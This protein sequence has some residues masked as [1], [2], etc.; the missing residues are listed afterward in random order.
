[1]AGNIFAQ[2]KV[3][4]EVIKKEEKKP[5]AEMNPSFNV[6]KIMDENPKKADSDEVKFSADSMESDNN[7][8]LITAIGNVD[9]EY[10]NMFLKADKVVYDQ[11]EDRVTATGNVK[12][13]QENGNVVYAD[14]VTAS[15]KMSKAFMEKIKVEMIDGT[16]IM[17]DS[18]RKRANNDKVIEKAMYTP[19]DFCEKTAP[20]W[21]INARKVKHDAASQDVNYNDAVLKVKNVPVIYTPYLSHPDPEVKRRSG[22]LAPT[23]GKN[24][25]LGATLQT[26][27]FFDIDEHQ[28]FTFTPIFT[29]DKEVVLMGKYNKYFYSGEMNVEGSYLHDK[30]DDHKEHRGNIFASG[31]YE[32]NNYWVADADLKYVSDNLYLKEL[33]LPQKDDAW[34]VSNVRMQMFDNRDYASIEAYYYDLVSYNLRSKRGRRYYQQSDNKPFVLP[35]MM[36]ENISDSNSVGAYFKNTFDFASVY[37][38]DDNNGQRMSMINSWILPYTSRFGEKYRFVASLKSDVYYINS[39]RNSYNKDYTGVA[40][41]VFPQVGVEWKYPFIRTGE[42]SS[43]IIEPVT[44]AVVAP[45]GGN[46]EH[47]IP[48]EDSQDVDLDD[49]NILNLDRF[50]GY[51]RNDTGSRISYGFNWSSYGERFGRTTAFIAQSYRFNRSESFARQMGEEGSFSDYVGRIYASPSKYFNLDYRFRADKDKLKIKYSELGAGI[52]SD[53]FKVYVSYIYIN[54]KLYNSENLRE[55]HELY[56]SI[57]SA[58]TKDWSIAL[59][60]RQDLTKD[61]GNL[62]HGGSLIYE[63]ECLKFMTNVSKYNSNNPNLDDGYSFGFTF[64]LKTLGGFGA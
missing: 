59:Y 53:I 26:P 35:L 2:E 9:I 17:A 50:S 19:C 11:N 45:N 62:E 8:G 18:F 5:F 15:D 13:T 23:I 4:G 34:L 21:Q 40:T 44:L 51:D 63:D 61:G 54:S 3:A 24:S 16:T 47:K 28:D 32:I 29:T 20:L 1:M 27:Y 38:E 36:Y 48:N 33:S 64:Y 58:L 39:Y 41:R 56:T 55:R 22:F 49:S 52:G 43:Q 60:N 42:S 31:R 37:H 10:N 14:Y 12:F 7:N 57:S 30:D 6:T 46:E 25:Y